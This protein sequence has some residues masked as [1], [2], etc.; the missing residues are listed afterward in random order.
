MEK[1]QSLYFSD[2]FAAGLE[3]GEQ[4]PDDESK[5]QEHCAALQIKFPILPLGFFAFLLVGSIPFRDFPGGMLPCRL[6]T[7]RAFRRTVIVLNIKPLLAIQAT[8]FQVV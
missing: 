1:R 7:M 6:S 3:T 8:R 2:R 4:P 5:H